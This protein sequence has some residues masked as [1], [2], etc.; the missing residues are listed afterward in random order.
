VFESPF[1][2]KLAQSTGSLHSFARLERGFPSDRG[3]A[4]LAY[5]QAES[6]VR[7]IV[8]RFGAAR[9]REIL[10]SMAEGTDFYMAFR[11]ATGVRFYDFEEEWVGYVGRFSALAW[12]FGQGRLLFFLGAIAAAVGWWFRRRRARRILKGWAAEEDEEWPA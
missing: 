9:L 12:V 7:F 1:Q 6:M 10:G 2:L 8:S 11:V 5:Q 4:A 3:G